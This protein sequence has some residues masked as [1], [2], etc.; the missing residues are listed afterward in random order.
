MRANHIKSSFIVLVLSVF[1]YFFWNKYSEF[2]TQGS[3]PSEAILKL[4]EMEEK[5]VPSFNLQDI[6]GNQVSLSQFKDQALILNFWASWCEPCVDELPSMIKL[7]KHF[8][9]KVVLLAV[10]ADESLQDLEEFLKAFRIKGPHIKVIWDKE[11][12][13]ARKFGTEVLPESYILGR[14]NRLHK[15]V[16]GEL[17]WDSLEAISFFEELIKRDWE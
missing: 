14:D 10:S 12:L 16:S 13:I 17:K 2:L 6:S 1:L 3:R 4:K 5:G 11:M 7:V 15:K 9:G 8:K